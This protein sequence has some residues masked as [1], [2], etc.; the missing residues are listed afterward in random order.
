MSAGPS[1]IRRRYAAGTSCHD[2]AAELNLSHARVCE[3]VG[4]TDWDCLSERLDAAEAQLDELTQ[5]GV[6]HEHR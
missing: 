2:L 4:I 1:E 3:L 6:D 5:G